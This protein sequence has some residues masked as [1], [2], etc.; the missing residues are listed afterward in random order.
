MG[1]DCDE[2]SGKA[3]KA[4]L[5]IMGKEITDYVK[6][7]SCDKVLIEVAFCK[8]HGSEGECVI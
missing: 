2:Q 4:K 6:Q 8:C 3:F 7:F 1:V 5:K